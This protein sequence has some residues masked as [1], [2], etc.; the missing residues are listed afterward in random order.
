MNM[1]PGAERCPKTAKSMNFERIGR[2]IE[3]SP[4][5]RRF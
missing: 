3:L 1:N 2:E 5:F 4:Y